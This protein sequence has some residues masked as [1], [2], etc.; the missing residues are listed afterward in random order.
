M[1]PGARVAQRTEFSL[2]TNGSPPRHTSVPRD[3]VARS[4]GIM[5]SRFQTVASG[6]GES[7]P[8]GIVPPRRTDRASAA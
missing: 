5:M 8:T 2:Q 6:H 3:F 7:V 1:N 4:D